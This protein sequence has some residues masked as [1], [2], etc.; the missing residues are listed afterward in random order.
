MGPASLVPASAAGPATVTILHFND[1][2]E[3][4]A[5]EAGKVGG[6]ARFAAVRARLKAQFPGLLTELAGDFVSPSALGTAVVD[7]RPLAGRQMVD[8]LNAVGLDWATLGNHEFDIGRDGLLARVREAKFHLVSSNVTDAATGAPF[9]GIATHAI[10]PVKA[11]GRTVRLGLLGLTIDMNRQPWVRYADPVESA[12]AAVAALKGKCDAIVALTHLTLA[13]D[14]QVAE[15]VPDIDV[16]LGGHEHENWLLERGPRFTPI[17]K[18]DA[19]VRTVA[20]VTLRIPG[21][22]RRPSVSSRLEQIDER[23]KEN[24]RVAAIVRKWTDLGLAAFRAQGF[25]PTEVLMVTPVA[26][27]GRESV[28]RNQPT[29]LTDLVAE[30]MRKEAGTDL[31]IFNA[32]SIRIDDVLVEAGPVTQYDVIRVL[33]FGGPVVRATFTGAL[34]SHVLEVGEQ[35]RTT[36]GFLHYAGITRDPDGFRV[37]GRPIDPAGRYTLAIT[38]FLL[39]GREAHLDFLTRTNR[40]VSDIADLRDVR[41]TV[42]DELRRRN[43]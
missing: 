22:G 37:N 32:G 2:Y 5:V 21:G 30:A 6:L 28:V 25:E 15:H 43:R 34:L 3:I 33:P 14:Q 13:G 10:V 16:I 7:G 31:S 20:L 17:V 26:L 4:S 12:R 24:P 18:A 41:L 8:V 38:D 9:P 39:T 27:D 23:V 29:R 35:N 40:D 42:I 1:I 19:N 11:Q 36:G